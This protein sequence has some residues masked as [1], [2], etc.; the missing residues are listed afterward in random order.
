MFLTCQTLSDFHRR[1]VE[2]DHP[3]QAGDVQV[4]DC[5]EA[6]Y[7]LAWFRKGVPRAPIDIAASL[8]VGAPS[9]LKMLWSPFVMNNTNPPNGS[10]LVEAH[11]PHSLLFECTA[12]ANPVTCRA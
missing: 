10:I 2:E 11:G 1:C 4:G 3:G 7:H 12:L 9:V 6:I 8:E 5:L